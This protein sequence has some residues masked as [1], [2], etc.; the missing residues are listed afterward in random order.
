M[1]SLTYDN[2]DGNFTVNNFKS[3]ASNS[4][5]FESFPTV[6]ISDKNG[7]SVIHFDS[8]QE[9]EEYL[10]NKDEN[11]SKTGAA[12]ALYTCLYYGTLFFIPYN[13]YSWLK[14]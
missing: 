11:H 7:T 12:F 4:S 13:I 9:Y 10:K 5:N 1:N 6:T 3:L 14:K 8:E 2:Y